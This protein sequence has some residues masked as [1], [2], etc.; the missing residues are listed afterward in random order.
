MHQLMFFEMEF[1]IMNA[2]QHLWAYRNSKH[3]LKSIENEGKCKVKIQLKTLSFN[4]NS[5]ASFMF[6]SIF[7]FES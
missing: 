4:E 6:H 1:L 3:E 5:L 2:I 7:S